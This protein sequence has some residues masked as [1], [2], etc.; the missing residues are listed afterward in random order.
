MRKSLKLFLEKKSSEVPVQLF[1]EILGTF[2]KN[3]LKKFMTILKEFLKKNPGGFL[4][5]FQK[6]SGRTARAISEA[7][8]R[9][10]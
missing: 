4:N 2:L 3:F 10:C 9:N 8:Q 6:K 7:I 5:K 1:N